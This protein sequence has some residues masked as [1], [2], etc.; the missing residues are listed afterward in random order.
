[1]EYRQDVSAEHRA[2][3]VV[4]LQKLIKSR[5]GVTVTVDAVEPA[6]LFR[7]TGKA[8]RLVDKRPKG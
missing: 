3:A 8:K 6:A 4:E 2:A 1:M 5:I 7:S